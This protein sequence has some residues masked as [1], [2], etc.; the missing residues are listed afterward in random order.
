ML[1]SA[2]GPVEGNATRGW[3][4]VCVTGTSHL[5][6]LAPAPVSVTPHFLGPQRW[7]AL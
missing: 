3:A 1:E 7:K 4:F 6:V 2:C 5:T